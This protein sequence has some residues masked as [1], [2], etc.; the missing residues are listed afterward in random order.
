MAAEGGSPLLARFLGK[1][2]R[3]RPGHPHAGEYAVVERLV[4]VTGVTAVEVR[5]EHC[6]HGVQRCGVFSSGDMKVVA[7]GGQP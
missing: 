4:R 2:V 3:L 6:P 5:L 1:R 7:E